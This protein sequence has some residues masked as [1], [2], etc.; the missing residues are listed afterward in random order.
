MNRTE[1]FLR[2]AER[3]ATASTHHRWKL[4]CVYTRGSQL[5]SRGAAKRRHHPTLDYRTAT[6]HAEESG[7]RRATGYPTKGRKTA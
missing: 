2:A 5:L 3:E 1:R 7:I 6:F 4:G